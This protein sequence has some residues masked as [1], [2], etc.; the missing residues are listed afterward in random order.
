MSEKSTPFKDY[1]ICVAH[2]MKS[3]RR[4]FSFLRRQRKFSDTVTSF[5]PFHFTFQKRKKVKFMKSRMLK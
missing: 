5:K 4:K 2:I 1:V 3:E